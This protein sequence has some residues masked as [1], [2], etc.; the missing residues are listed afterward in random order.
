M[1]DGPF[2]TP[3]ELA[4]GRMIRNAGSPETAG[5][6]LIERLEALEAAVDALERSAR[7]EVEENAEA[8]EQAE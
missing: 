1:P 4:L 5:R 2:P 8:E 3:D 7:E 6:S